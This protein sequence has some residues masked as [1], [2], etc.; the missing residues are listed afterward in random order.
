ME[1]IEAQ[2]AEMTRIVQSIRWTIGVHSNSGKV[3][4]CEGIEELR[5]LADNLLQD[6][7]AAAENCECKCTECS[8]SI[9]EGC[10]CERCSDCNELV[11]DCVCL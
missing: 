11:L 3:C 2:L 1:E 5:G 7:E 9:E 6:I 10:E 8:E 4:F